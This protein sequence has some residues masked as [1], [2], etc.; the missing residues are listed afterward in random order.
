MVL[1]LTIFLLLHV[2]YQD[3]RERSVLLISFGL[4]LVTGM[5]LKF[6]YMELYIALLSIF[7][8]VAVVSFV[9]FL[10]FLYIR[11]KMNLEFKDAIG[12]GDIFLWIV[13]AISFSVRTFIWVFSLSMIFSLIVTWIFFREKKDTIPLAGLQAVFIAGILLC[14]FSFSNLESLYR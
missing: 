10:L 2:A 14:N 1:F 12:M 9:V 11:Y 8:N 7:I 3:L 13:M 6:T 4:L 5:L